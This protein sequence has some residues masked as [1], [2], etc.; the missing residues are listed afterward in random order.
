MLTRSW[1][2]R[3]GAALAVWSVL[4][5]LVGATTASASAP[6]LLRVVSSPA[7]P[8]QIVVDRQVA[9][10]WGLTWLKLAPGTHTVCFAHVEGYTE[11]P[12][13]TV[14]LN[15]GATTTVTG[16]FIRRGELRVITSPAVAS[17]I[18]VD[19]NPT[20]DWGMWTDVSAGPHQVCFGKVAGY[21]PPACQSAVLPAGGQIT[22]TGAF[23]ADPAAVG[24]SG[25]GSLRVVTSLA[26]APQIMITPQGGSRYIADS[27]GLNWLELP[28]GSYTVSFTHVEG[29]TEPAPQTITITSGNTTTVTG[30]FTQRGFLR[31]TTSPAV[32][33]TMTVDSVPRN[34]WGM[35][36]DVPTGSYTVC[37]GPVIGYLTPP[38][39]QSVAVNA[40]VETDVIGTYNLIPW[41]TTGSMTVPRYAHTATLL[42]N[43]KVLVAG[44]SA[45]DSYS[46]SAELYDPATG[47]WAATGSMATARYV[48]TATLLSNGKVLVAGGYGGNAPLASA[49]LYDPATGIWSTTGSMAT[50]RQSQTATLLSNGKVLV[51][52]GNDNGG[53]RLASVELYDPATGTWSTTAGMAAGRSLHTATLLSN[54]KVLVTG[55]EGSQGFL[56]SAELYDPATG[57]WS[58]TGSMATGRQSQTATLLSNSKVLV[59]GGNGGIPLASAEL[60]DPATGTW[61]T[62]ASM[63]DARVYHTATLLPNGYVLVA[64]GLN[65]HGYLASAELFDPATGLWWTTG[66]MATARYYHTATLLSNGQVLVAGGGPPPGALVSAELYPAA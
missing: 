52:G 32:A 61:S 58:T 5:T 45:N 28:P 56:A 59:T 12:C 21:D 8:T 11:P 64:A 65:S 4:A 13:Q 53:L 18:T 3:L 49:E 20:D 57:T 26:S 50:G 34:D 51:T 63:A 10:T 33:G 1:M 17:Q 48:H 24:Q 29:F 62:T 39:C 31:V 40:G 66:S 2:S 9:D 55:G 41:A 22:F 35:W 14:A 47:T 37:F 15:G 7:L 38:P 25:V 44:G 36:T 46:A 54:S 6:S 43:G 27:W 42:P 60:Y 16:T 23:T 19:G 30:T